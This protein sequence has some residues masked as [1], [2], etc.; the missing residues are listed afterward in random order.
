M[1]RRKRF[2]GHD[3]RQAAVPSSSPATDHKVNDNST[4]LEDDSP[5]ALPAPSALTS[6][7]KDGSNM[8]FDVYSGLYVN[9]IDMAGK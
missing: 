8:S 5:D 4:S 1:P 7:N 6:Q 9:D 3:Q 2:V